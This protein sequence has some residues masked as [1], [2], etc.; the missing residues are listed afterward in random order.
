MMLCCGQERA[1][2]SQPFFGS[3]IGHR[4]ATLSVLLFSK[5]S[6]LI[7]WY[8]DSDFFY[9]ILKINNFWGDL[10]DMSA[11]NEALDSTRLQILK[12]VHRALRQL[13]RAIKFF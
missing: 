3:S 5:L 7:F 13:C 2:Q 1:R 6:N 9:Q 12:S 11:K 10:T 4:M 8:F